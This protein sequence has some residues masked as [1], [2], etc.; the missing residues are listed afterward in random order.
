MANKST[1]PYSTDFASGDIDHDL[2][3][4]T[5]MRIYKREE[6]QTHVGPNTLPYELGSLPERFGAMVDNGIQAA[7]IIEDFLKTPDVKHEKELMRLKK[8][9]EKIVLYLIQNVDYILEKQT[10]GAKHAIDDV[11]DELKEKELYQ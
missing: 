11:K 9:T 5:Q 3:P 1:S 8:N 10:I 2:D 7:K 4:S 6:R